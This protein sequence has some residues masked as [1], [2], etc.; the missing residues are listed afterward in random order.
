MPYDLIKENDFKHNLENMYEKWVFK[1]LSMFWVKAKQEKRRKTNIVRI[2]MKCFA[3]LVDFILFYDFD[4]KSD[5][6]MLFHNLCQAAG[7]R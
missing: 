4:L 5:N 6:V 3:R 7:L 2:F 1:Q